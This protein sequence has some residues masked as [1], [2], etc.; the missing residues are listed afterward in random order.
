MR[1]GPP[2]IV[3][4]ESIFLSILY[5]PGILIFIHIVKHGLR[6]FQ[7]RFLVNSSLTIA[8]GGGGGGG[9]GEEGKGGE[10]REAGGGGGGRG[11]G[12]E[13]G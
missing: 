11:G 9:G 5:N 4:D 3:Q 1:L 7:F 6:S 12:E 13:G 10:G 8:S 2:T